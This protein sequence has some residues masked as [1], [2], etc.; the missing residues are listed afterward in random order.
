MQ[1]A[2]GTLAY[3]VT[4]KGSRIHIHANGPSLQP[5]G[6]KSYV[7]LLNDSAWR[8]IQTTSEIFLWKDQVDNINSLPQFA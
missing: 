1:N 8:G 4:L 7:P 2:H 6:V 3:L 5:L